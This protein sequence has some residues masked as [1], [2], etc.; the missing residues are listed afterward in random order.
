MR[1]MPHVGTVEE[2]A[3]YF[4]QHPLTKHE[5]AMLIAHAEAGVLT[6][7][8]IAQAAGWRSFRAGNAQYGRFARKIREFIGLPLNASSS[9]QAIHALALFDDVGK[10]GF[11]E[12]LLRIHDEVIQGARQEGLLPDAS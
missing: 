10:D 7:R 1:R 6:M 2:Y 12:Y 9:G 5:R 4:R 11:G 3:A 8:Q